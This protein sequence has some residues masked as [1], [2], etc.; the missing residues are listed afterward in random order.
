MVVGHDMTLSDPT[1]NDLPGSS[2]AILDLELTPWHF[3]RAAAPIRSALLA[4]G[5]MHTRRL[6]IARIGIGI[7]G[8]GLVVLRLT[9]ATADSQQR[10]A[11]FAA[12]ELAALPKANW[13]KNGGNL[14]NQNYSP[15]AQINRETVASLKGVWRT[16][17]NSSGMAAKYSGEAQPVARRNDLCRDGRG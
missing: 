10:S 17:L 6:K 3:H 11:A 1:N 5:L 16:H 7:I 2:R 13:L 15:L 12:S 8:V 9:A 14:F 4:G